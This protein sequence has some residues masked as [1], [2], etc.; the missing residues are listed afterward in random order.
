MVGTR[1]KEILGSVFV[2]GLLDGRADPKA[3]QEALGLARS[4]MRRRLRNL[5]SK[6]LVEIHRSS[7]VLTGKGRRAFK[8]VFIG[9][10]F[11]IIHPGHLYTIEQAKKLGDI[12]VAVI[13]RDSTVRRRKGRDPIVPEEERR[14]LISAMR[15]VDVAILGSVT[16]IY[17]TLE[18][19][20]PDV[21]ALGY[22]QYHGEEEIARE[23]KRRGLNLSVVRLESPIPSLKTSKI[24]TQI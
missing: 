4:E 16:N 19:V 17:D 7:V 23:A 21:V 3:L 12:L 13:A 15:D 9:G 14:R 6:G 2:H 10:S 24:L 11:E 1:D 18:K 8:V 22:D 5:A 20:R